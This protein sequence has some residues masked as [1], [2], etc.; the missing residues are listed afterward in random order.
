MPI[1]TF[2]IKMFAIILLAVL[3]HSN[4]IFVQA[5]DAETKFFLSKIKKNSESLATLTK[6]ETMILEKL[7][8]MILNRIVQENNENFWIL[9][10]G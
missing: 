10:Q 2:K 8:T 5:Y 9:R 4:F 7:K 1:E 3:I 6:I